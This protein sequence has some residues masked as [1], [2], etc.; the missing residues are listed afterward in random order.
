MHDYDYALQKTKWHKNRK[1]IQN[2]HVVSR[3]KF[4]VL[5]NGALVFD[6]SLFF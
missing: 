6:V 5:S 3:L 1:Q 4:C 2:V